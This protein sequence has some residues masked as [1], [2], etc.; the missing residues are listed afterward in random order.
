MTTKGAYKTQSEIVAPGTTS[1]K[2]VRP[3]TLPA[4]ALYAPETRAT[5]RRLPPRGAIVVLH[6]VDDRLAEFRA[7]EQLRPGHQA[8]EIVGDGLVGKRLLEPANNSVSCLLPSH[9][10]EHHHPRQDDRAGVDLI[11]VRVLGRG[12]MG[13]LEDRVASHVV[14]VGARRDAQAADLRRQRVGKVIAVKVHG[15]DH[16]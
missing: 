15:R 10:L 8:L 6:V 9:V 13:G 12:A 7:L 3:Q 1:L 4:G 5:P 2:Q 14:D 16:V 11:L